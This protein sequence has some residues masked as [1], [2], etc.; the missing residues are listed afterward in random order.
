MFTL[1]ASPIWCAAQ[2]IP[3]TAGCSCRRRAMTSLFLPTMTLAPSF[4]KPTSFSCHSVS[5]T[6]SL[7]IA[8][9]MEARIPGAFARSTFTIP[10][11]FHSNV[12][13]MCM[14]YVHHL[15]FEGGRVRRAILDESQE[16]GGLDVIADP[17]ASYFGDVVGE[18]AGL[19]VVLVRRPNVQPL[20]LV[21]IAGPDEV[22]V[23]T[24]MPGA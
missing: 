21:H 13:M 12:P 22:S 20:L 9:E 15:G 2:C 17:A 23:R 19:L 4:P 5:A 11:K 7:V 1:Y 3:C 18:D 16:R 6:P 10:R 8:V 14:A 24:S